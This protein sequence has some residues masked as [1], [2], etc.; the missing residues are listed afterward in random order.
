MDTD[1]IFVATKAIRHAVQNY[2]AGRRANRDAREE[3][4]TELIALLDNC[5]STRAATILSL[6]SWLDILYSGKRHQRYRNSSGTGADV[7]KRYIYQCLDTIEK[8]ANEI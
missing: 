5:P 3:L 4:D 8:R 1:K 2:A 7:V 6:S